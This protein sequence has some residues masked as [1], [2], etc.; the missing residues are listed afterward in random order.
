MDN[1]KELEAD[2]MLVAIGR[3]ANTS[4]LGL[5]ELGVAGTEAEFLR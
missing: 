1:G 2:I 5:E 4:N 3:K